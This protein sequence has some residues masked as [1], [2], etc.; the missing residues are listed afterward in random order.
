MSNFNLDEGLY[1]GKKEV[2][3]KLVWDAKGAI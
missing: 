1:L 3:G 2:M